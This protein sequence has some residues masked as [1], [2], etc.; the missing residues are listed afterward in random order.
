MIKS[1]Q[2]LRFQFPFRDSSAPATSGE[3]VATGDHGGDHDGTTHLETLGSAFIALMRVFSLPFLLTIIFLARLAP[4]TCAASASLRRLQMATFKE[5]FRKQVMQ[6]SSKND[7][8]A[9]ET[10]LQA[11]DGGAEA[12]NMEGPLLKD[13]LDEAL[14]HKNNEAY[15]ML[16]NRIGAA[17]R[18]DVE[19]EEFA[20]YNSIADIMEHGIEQKNMGLMKRLA[21]PHRL[22]Y[23]REDPRFEQERLMFYLMKVVKP[24]R[25]DSQLVDFIVD[26][27]SDEV[28][29]NKV[30]AIALRIAKEQDGCTEFA[31]Q[32][33][34]RLPEGYNEPLDEMLFPSAQDEPKQAA[35]SQCSMQ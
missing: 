4:L 10:L 30:L 28:T 21:D 9:I 23:A 22:L 3:M 33:Q 18:H 31:A 6:A 11:D 13:A 32:I 27:H 19:S 14:K 8:A 7:A 25:V 35:T 2:S 1:P 5:G 17:L 16:C 24:G 29:E 12:W 26:L 15:Q 20:M 34:R